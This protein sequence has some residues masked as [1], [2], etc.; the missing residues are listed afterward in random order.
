M[1]AFQFMTLTQLGRIFGVSNQNVGKWLVEL[2]LRTTDHIPSDEARQCGFVDQSYADNG[3][4]SWTRHTEKTVSALEAAGHLRIL[5]P[6]IGLIDP[7]L[8]KGPFSMRSC[9]DGT[10]QILSSDGSIA[11][12]VRGERNA[13]L[14]LK[15]LRIAERCGFIAKHLCGHKQ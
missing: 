11:V 1:Y 5:N 9:G 3:T 7:P 15:I 13:I 6:P 8:L 4:C 12:A 2:G 14:I 10:F